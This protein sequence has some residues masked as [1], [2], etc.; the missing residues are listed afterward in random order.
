MKKLTRTE[1]QAIKRLHKKGSINEDLKKGI[2]KKALF[3][4]VWKESGDY[5]SC[6]LPLWETE[7]HFC[8]FGSMDKNNKSFSYEDLKNLLDK[9]ESECR[10]N[11]DRLGYEKHKLALFD[12]E[13]GSFLFSIRYDLGDSEKD[14]L[15]GA[16]LY[17]LWLNPIVKKEREQEKTINMAG[18]PESQ[19]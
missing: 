14:S 18:I 8:R 5:D 11:K 1:K 9:D 12:P 7:Q 2:T 10:K 6:I 3:Q 13:D 15:E 4:L 19:L 16:M 17:G